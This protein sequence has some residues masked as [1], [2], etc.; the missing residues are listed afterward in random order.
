MI[1]SFG[2]S[3]PKT[4]PS[5][6]VHPAAEVIG[7]VRLGA[8]SSV[9]P[10]AVLRGDVGDIIVGARSNIQD[11]AVVHCRERRPAVIGR[12]V[13]VGHAA[14][15]HG[16]R[17]GERCLIGMGA[18]VMEAVVGKECLIG[19]GALVPPGMRIPPRRLV[20]GVPARVMRRLTAQ[21]LMSLKASEDSYVRLARR[22]RSSSRLLP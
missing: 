2:S 22:H 3:R 12:G 4:D 9:W 15:V 5:A 17:I 14:V 21:E 10:M 18:T 19:A 7:R 16:A 6:F 11:G 1:R 20:L 13:T 8:D